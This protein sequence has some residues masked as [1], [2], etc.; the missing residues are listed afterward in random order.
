MKV[1]GSLALA[2]GGALIA[3]PFSASAAD[4]P[5]AFTQCKACHN[6]EAGKNGIGP[7]LAGVFGRKVGQAEGFKYSEPHLKSGLTMDEA[8]LTK[9]LADPKGVIPGN[10]MVFLGLKNPDDVKAVIAYL[11]TL[12]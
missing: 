7:S 8:T 12:K 4:A 5:P 10:K 1:I 11:K 9:Y 2:L 6:V 3:L